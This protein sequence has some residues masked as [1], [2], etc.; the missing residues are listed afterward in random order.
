M[1]GL[2]PRGGLH[3]LVSVG[4]AQVMPLFTEVV[5]H[6]D[7][8]TLHKTSLT[9]ADGSTIMLY[10]KLLALLLRIAS[11]GGAEPSEIARRTKE[12]LDQFERNEDQQKARGCNREEGGGVG[13]ASV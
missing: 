2:E 13:W 6:R 4:R 3:A 7:Y 10:P 12:V 5:T 9:M 11:G 8:P 1:R